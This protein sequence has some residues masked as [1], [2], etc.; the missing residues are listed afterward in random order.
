ML[1]RVT[2]E[3]LRHLVDEFGLIP[4]SDAELNVVLPQ[5]Q[6]Q[7]DAV[8]A[9]KEVDVTG[10]RTSH[11]F[12]ASL[13]GLPASGEPDKLHGFSAPAMPSSLEARRTPTGPGQ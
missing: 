5:I 7:V 6:S 11:V 13:S 2:R 10:V 8:Q 9:A 4:M 3:T 1:S 12:H